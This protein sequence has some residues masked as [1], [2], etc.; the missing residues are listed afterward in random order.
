[1]I[2]VM[3]APSLPFVR[4]WSGA[5]A[6]SAA[7]WYGYALRALWDAG[8]ETGVDPVVLAAQC[9]L[10]TNWGRFGGAVDA[11]FNNTCGLKTVNGVGDEPDD[12]QRFPA[13]TYGRPW[14]GAL[15]HA[16][17]LRL[18]CGFPVPPDTPDPRAR[19]VGS[20]SRNFGSVMH[21]EDLSGRW[22][23]APDYGTRI[24]RIVEQVF[25]RAEG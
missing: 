23:P 22:A 12:H 13:D 3:S 6:S 14:L 17:H 5:S 25:R 20:G 9:A 21:V 7:S 1:M 16:H 18:Y 10:E 8:V 15:A 2:P 24:V 4:L 11:S 19:H